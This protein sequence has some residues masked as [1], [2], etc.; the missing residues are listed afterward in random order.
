MFTTIF[1][2]LKIKQR[3]FLGRN[4]KN[5]VRMFLLSF[6]KGGKRTSKLFVAFQKTTETSFCSTPIQKRGGGGVTVVKGFSFQPGSGV[7][8]TFSS[9]DVFSQVHNRRRQIVKLTSRGCS[10]GKKLTFE[11]LDVGVTIDFFL[12]SHQQ[13]HPSPFERIFSV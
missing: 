7:R 8:R 13:K 10:Q 4:S 9:G 11:R 6:L 2:L 12:L 5:V 3:V 1:K